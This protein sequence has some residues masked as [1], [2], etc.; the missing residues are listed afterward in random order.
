MEDSTNSNIVPIC[1]WQLW[2][3]FRDESVLA[4]VRADIQPA[5]STDGGNGHRLDIEQLKNRPLLQSVYSESLRLNSTIYCSRY[6][7][8][9]EVQVNEW[10]FPKNSILLIPTHSAHQ[11]ET[12]WNTK[13]GRFPLDKF[14][15]DRFLVYEGDP[16]SGPGLQTASMARPDDKGSGSTSPRFTMDGV[17]GSYFPYGDGCRVCPGRF[18]AKNV[19]LVALALMVRDYDVDLLVKGRDWKPRLDPMYHGFGGEFPMD[20]I[21]FRIR[22]RARPK[23]EA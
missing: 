4:R 19:M 13:D 8:D 14:W 22:K 18:F 7:G 6:T 1:M 10:V 2:D 17:G 21:P 11:D 3:V 16:S 20:K 15:A 5:L 12:V 23:Q 9:K